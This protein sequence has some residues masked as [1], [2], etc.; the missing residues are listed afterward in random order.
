VKGA[1]T[2]RTGIGA[3]GLAIG[4]ACG[5][6]AGMKVTHSAP[7]PP[8][9]T[10]FLNF[11]P[12]TTGPETLTIG[13]SGFEQTHER[14]SFVWCAS[15]HCT[16]VVEIHGQRDRRIRIRLWPFRYPN[17][18]PQ[19]VVANVNGVSVGTLDLGEKPI[20]WDLAVAGTVWKEG[21]NV[22]RFDFEYAETP[23]G[24]IPNSTDPRTLSAGFDWLEILPS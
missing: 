20:V 9:E 17:A 2:S 22:L 24:R 3:I 18:P 4:M 21:R 23:A 1:L 15:K 14:D 7:S 19:M 10:R 6:V 11:D 8:P 5:L 16:A 13:W 12:E